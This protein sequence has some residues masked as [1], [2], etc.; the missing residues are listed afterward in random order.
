MKFKKADNTYRELLERQT[1]TQRTQ[2]TKM[3]SRDSVMAFTDEQLEELCD[4][5]NTVSTFIK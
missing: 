5:F 4:T 3:A 2:S 1:E